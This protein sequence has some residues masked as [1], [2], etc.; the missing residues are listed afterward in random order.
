MLKL[1]VFVIGCSGFIGLVIVKVLLD[2]YLDKVNIIVGIRDLVLE[3]VVKLKILLGVIV[4][5][6]DMID[7]EVLGE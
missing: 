4:V 1:I 2:N 3:K 7:K 6:V 5:R